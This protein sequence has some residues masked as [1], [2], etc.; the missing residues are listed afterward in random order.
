MKELPLASHF[1]SS[2]NKGMTDGTK[3]LLTLHGRGDTLDSYKMFAKELNVT[4]L[5]YLLLNAPFVEY[6]G[7]TWYDDSYSRNDPRYQVSIK[8]LT[9]CLKQAVA[10]SDGNLDYK[11]ILLFGFSQ[12]GR[13]V[14]DLL[15]SFNGELGAVIALSPRMSLDHDFSAI[16][17]SL[18]RT[19]V[20]IAHGE[21][22][23]VI[24]LEETKTGADQWSKVINDFTFKTYPCGHEIDPIELC[25]LRAWINNYL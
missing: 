8:K 6:F 10:Q 17:P 13:M 16:N 21:Y 18:S 20:F 25:D 12:G 22:D 5:N 14:L 3:V 23:E 2:V 11:D 24:P 15:K 4:G 7:Y 1:I 19:P 9:E